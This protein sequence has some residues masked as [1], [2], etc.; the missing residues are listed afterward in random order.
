[1][2]NT[3]V[4]PKYIHYCWFGGRALPKQYQAYINTWKKFFPD[5][6]LIRWDETIFPIDQFVYA[7]E[8]M[9][10]GKMAFVSDVARIYALEKMGGIYFDTDVEVIRSFEDILIDENAVL[11]TET[12]GQ[13]I[14]TGFMA[15]TPGHRICKKMLEY[16][17]SHSYKDQSATLSNTIILASIIKEEYGITPDSSIHRSSDLIIYPQE[18]FT[19]YN[20][21]TGRHKVT[22]KTYCIHHFSASWFSPARKMKDKL[23]QCFHRL[24]G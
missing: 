14:G 7:Q 8:A 24:I 13:T 5:Y 17:K 16:Y 18:Y 10:A 15:F 3:P 22:D 23:K 9:E 6:K 21:Y 19:A 20:G 2:K 11:G 12:E 1:M 4:I